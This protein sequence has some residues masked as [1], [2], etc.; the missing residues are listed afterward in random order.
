M[1]TN[2]NNRE[3]PSKTWNTFLGNQNI[4]IWTFESWIGRERS[5]RKTLYHSKSN[6]PNFLYDRLSKSKLWFALTQLADWKS[7]CAKFNTTQKTIY[8]R[9]RVKTLRI[10]IVEI[11][12]NN[13]LIN[14]VNF[15]CY[16]ARGETNG[17]FKFFDAHT[18]KSL[19]IFLAW[20]K[21]VKLSNS[22][23]HNKKRH[24]SISWCD[25]MLFSREWRNIYSIYD[26]YDLF[27]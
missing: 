5:S 16:R 9:F 22:D 13:N 14:N 23:F 12:N 10:C 17:K 8:R 24:G 25:N 7:S 1:R 21:K 3:Q 6:S 18:K 2:N 20:S 27:Q 11:C 26:N 15:T 19:T 4:F